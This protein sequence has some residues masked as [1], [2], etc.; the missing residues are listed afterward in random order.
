MQQRGVNEASSGPY[1]WLSW[2]TVELL[3]VKCEC[4]ECLC[5]FRDFH[6]D[7]VEVSKIAVTSSFHDICFMRSKLAA[8]SRLLCNSSSDG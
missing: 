3:S 6:L 7:K 4:V 5:W 1:A 2:H 8:A